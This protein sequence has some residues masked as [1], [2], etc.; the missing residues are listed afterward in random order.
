MSNRIFHPISGCTR[1]ARNGKIKCQNKSYILPSEFLKEIIQNVTNKQPNFRYQKEIDKS[2]PRVYDMQ[3]YDINSFELGHGHKCVG[4]R[5]EAYFK[6]T[7]KKL[8]IPT[9]DMQIIECKLVKVANRR[10]H[11]TFHF[12][13]NGKIYFYGFRGVKSD[14]TID[15]YCTRTNFK[16]KCRSVVHISPSEFLKK[17]IQNTPKEFR[18]V[19]C[20]YY[21]KFFDKSE[22]RVYNIK[23]YEMNSFQSIGGHICQGI[24]PESYYKNI[25]PIQNENVEKFVMATANNSSHEIAECVEKI[26]PIFID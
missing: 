7:E 20:T 3:N 5:L 23:N 14:Y 2:D 11:P 8:Q 9:D 26:E 17:I 13:I 15:L 12:E 25:F 21:P 22:P 6:L 16:L 19:T 10:G 4:T 1:N 24:E 18:T